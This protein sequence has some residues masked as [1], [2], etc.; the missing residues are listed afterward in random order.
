[1][2]KSY[3]LWLYDVW[4][5]A[6]D[7]Y[8]V[9][10][11][12]PA[13]TGSIYDGETVIIDISDTDTNYSINRKLRIRGVK[14]DLFSALDINGQDINGQLKRNWKPFGFLRFIEDKV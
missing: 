13:F 8:D 9:N 10:N 5:N 7:G 11:W 2:S 3:Q 12:N 14:W 6:K 4:G 1:M